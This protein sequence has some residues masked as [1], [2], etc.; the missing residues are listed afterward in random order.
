LQPAR[1]RRAGLRVWLRHVPLRPASGAGPAAA[2]AA[3]EPVSHASPIAP[4]AVRLSPPAGSCAPRSFRQLMRSAPLATDGPSASGCAA[5]VPILSRLAPLTVEGHWRLAAPILQLCF[6]CAS[7][8]WPSM[9]HRPF[10]SAAVPSASVVLHAVPRTRGFRGAFF[11]ATFCIAAHR[12]VGLPWPPVAG[13]SYIYGVYPYHISRA[14]RRPDTQCVHRCRG[15][16]CRLCCT[17]CPEPAGSGGHCLVQALLRLPRAF[18][19][20]LVPLVAPLARH[21]H[22][23]WYRHASRHLSVPLVAP[24]ARCSHRRWYR[25]IATSRVPHRWP[26]RPSVEPCSPLYIYGVHVAYLHSHA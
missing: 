25:H 2:Q 23:R 6:R 10:S 19:V 4:R 13:A 12:A 14:T 11:G 21:S 26:V 1:P 5:S 22:R 8:R 18:S 7:R 17:T 9:G 24:L 16:A 3:A 20:V 15:H